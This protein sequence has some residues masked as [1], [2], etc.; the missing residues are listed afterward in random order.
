[1]PFR[2]RPAP[3]SHPCGSRRG[4]WAHGTPRRHKALRGAQGTAIGCDALAGGKYPSA[5]AQQAV[6]AAVG[7]CQKRSEQCVR[8]CVA[9]QETAARGGF[10]Q[11]AR[12]GQSA[13]RA[14]AQPAGA[15]RMPS[16]APGRGAVRGAPGYAMLAARWHTVAPLRAARLPHVPCRAVPCRAVPCWLPVAPVVL[17]A[18]Q[19]SCTPWA[20][21]HALVVHT[22]SV[23]TT[24]RSE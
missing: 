9:P 18:V 1:M 6:L 17:R 22:R 13:Q 16:V 7:R 11:G 2:R 4:E 23:C 12:R 5:T 10:V 15:A 20:A 19:G 8:A 24:S 3:S 21:K 14:E